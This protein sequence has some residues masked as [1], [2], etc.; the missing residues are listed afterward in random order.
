MIFLVCKQSIVGTVYRSHL[1]L[2]QLSFYKCKGGLLEHGVPE[3]WSWKCGS[4]CF[5]A[6]ISIWTMLS[7]SVCF[8]FPLSWLG[9]RIVIFYGFLC[10]RSTGK[11]SIA[12]QTDERAKSRGKDQRFAFQFIWS[13]TDQVEAKPL[14]IKY[15][16]RVFISC[17]MPR[18]C[19]YHAW[20][21]H[22]TC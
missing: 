10:I 8:M 17:V 12:L 1:K 13:K 14:Q 2:D 15:S 21:L 18:Y 22:V 20:C 5:N 6:C 16:S 7:W 19:G 9:W 4:L 3:T 11:W